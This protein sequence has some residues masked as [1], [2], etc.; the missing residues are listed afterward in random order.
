MNGLC[1][2]E[3]TRGSARHI[4]IYEQLLIRGFIAAVEG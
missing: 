4:V 1:G 3:Q 2:R